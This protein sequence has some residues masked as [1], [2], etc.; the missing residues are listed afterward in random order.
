MKRAA[1]CWL[2]V[3]VASCS[4]GASSSSTVVAPPAPPE[5]PKA[6]LLFTMSESGVGPIDATTA[7]DHDTLVAAFPDYDVVAAA[8]G[9]GL[10]TVEVRQG[11]EL[12]LTIVSSAAEPDKVYRA[13]SY[14]PRVGRI[15]K[16]VGDPASSPIIVE[17]QYS[18]CECW[19]GQVACWHYKDHIW[20]VYDKTCTGD[21]GDLDDAWAMASHASIIG[22][23]WGA[24]VHYDEDG[25]PTA[26]M[27]DL[28]AVGDIE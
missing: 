7:F 1:L 3:L 27:M 15:G 18:G 28:D 8:D 20:E 14:S 4:G 10:P 24:D 5:A 25:N 9:D 21:E 26:L 19:G 11:S 6:P 16:R 12:L 22:F 13:I 23:T 2:V 17:E